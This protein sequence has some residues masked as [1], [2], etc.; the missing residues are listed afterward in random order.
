M[1]KNNVNII[2]AQFSPYQIRISW[3]TNK[4]PSILR[5]SL[6]DHNS[7][8]VEGY[9][10]ISRTAR[11]EEEIDFLSSQIVNEFNSLLKVKLFEITRIPMIETLNHLENTTM[12]NSRWTAQST[13]NMRLTYFRRNILPSIQHCLYD[14]DFTPYNRQ[15]LIEHLERKCAQNGNSSTEY[16]RRKSTVANSLCAAQYIYNSMR[17][18][19]P[20][21]PQITL[22]EPQLKS[23]YITTEAIKY[24]P[25]NVAKIIESQI[26]ELVTTEPCLA[27]A[28]AVYYYQGLRTAE[29]AAFNS[30]DT[31]CSNEYNIT[32]VSFQEINGKRNPR[33][34]TENSYR[35]IPQDKK[36]S[37]IITITNQMLRESDDDKTAPISSEY[38]SKRI[39]KMLIDAGITNED[40][41]KVE[42]EMSENPELDRDGIP[43]RDVEAYILRRNR[44]TIW[45]NYCGLNKEEVDYLLGHARYTEGSKRIN[46]NKPEVYSVIFHK[47]KNFS[48]FSTFNEFS[49]NRITLSSAIEQFST[50][51]ATQTIINDTDAPA[52]IRVVVSPCEVGDYINITT[53][54]P[55]SNLTITSS[56]S[57]SRV[58][59]DLIGHIEKGD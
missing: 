48:A 17:I 47:I 27:R 10:Q 7:Q 29:A 49:L 43:I 13:R 3:S 33:L 26:E 36:C 57:F 40:I 34:K 59:T 18:I 15:Q 2:A 25:N 20:H 44:S 1:K 52:R 53:F 28:L 32:A 42:A 39:R 50:A 11:V 38:L 54:K 12:L 41:V 6:M 14:S 19:D 9:P 23:K 56:K 46:E 55:L 45:S 51:H 58:K 5:G 31:I 8:Y 37:N 4:F 21:L 24:L 16:N 30:F 22:F 35:R